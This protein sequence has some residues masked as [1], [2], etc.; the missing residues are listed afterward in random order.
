[1]EY[2]A[3]N[4]GHIQENPRDVCTAGELD[5]K[6]AVVYVGPTVRLVGGRH[7]KALKTSDPFL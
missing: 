6:L 3:T 1:M 7:R 2:T 4:E 5:L